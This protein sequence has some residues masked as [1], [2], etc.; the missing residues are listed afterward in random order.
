MSIIAGL[1]ERLRTEPG[2]GKSTWRARTEWAGGFKTATYARD[3]APVHTDEP[4][5]LAG[6]DTAPNPV[7]LV[8]AALGS[9]LTVGYAAAAAAKASSC[10]PSRLR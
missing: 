5:S 8:L 9:C 2:K 7:E 3:H 4:E 10:A 6:T 1:A